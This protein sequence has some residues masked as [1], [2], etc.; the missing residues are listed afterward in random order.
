MLH[1]ILDYNCHRSI[2]M[3]KF[4]WFHWRMTQ[5]FMDIDMILGGTELFF[6]PYRIAFLIFWVFLCLWI[7]QRFEF[8]SLIS[9]KY[10]PWINLLMLLF[11]PFVIFA[12]FIIAVVCRI[13]QGSVTVGG[14][15]VEVFGITVKKVSRKRRFSG[16]RGEESLVLLDPSG[17]SITEVYGAQSNAE[18]IGETENRA[19][20]S[21]KHRL[22]R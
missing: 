17:K 8:S 10:R 7:V 20:P 22:N 13:Y 2:I 9:Q 16:S 11:A 12:A 5:G 1:N 3:V 18:R 21:D 14:A 4:P 19:F 6:N 15:I